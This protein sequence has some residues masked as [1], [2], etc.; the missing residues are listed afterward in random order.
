MEGLRSGGTVHPG[1]LSPMTER[2][3]NRRVETGH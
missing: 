1:G 2:K 3:G